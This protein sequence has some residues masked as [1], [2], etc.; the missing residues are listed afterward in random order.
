MKDGRYKVAFTQLS[1]PREEYVLKE[2]YERVK[3]GY[4]A[5]VDGRP[6]HL[7]DVIFTGVDIIKINDVDTRDMAWD[8]DLFLWFKWSG[9]RIEAKESR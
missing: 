5:V 7:V 8:A 2:L 9:D 1:L 6:Y 3:K 4:V